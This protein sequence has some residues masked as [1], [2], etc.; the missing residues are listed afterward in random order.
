MGKFTKWLG[1][2]LGFTFGGPIGAII[3][4][5][6]GSVIDGVSVQDYND[7]K[8][9][10]KKQ[11]K[12]Y[13]KQR[14]E[15]DRPRVKTTTSG[16]FEIS[17]LVLASVVIKADGKVDQVE[18]DY[19]RLH[20]INLYGKDRA[21]HAFK[22]FNGIIKKEVSTR[23]VCI[24]IREHMSHSSRLQLIHFLFGIS[25]ADGTV[26][27]SEEEAIQKIAGYLYINT[28][29]Y[30]SIK[31]MFYNESDAAYKILEINKNVTDDEVKKA[32]RKMAKKYHPD[33][34]QDIGEEHKK[35]A[36]EK[37][38]NIQKAYENIKNERNIT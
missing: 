22:L 33:R 8:E 25:K 11:Q 21:N 34:L 20:F 35:A 13:K 14:K 2:G 5:A 23:Q 29:D 30:S 32:Y 15:Q 17:L 19:V 10:Y 31:A 1:A 18:L 7:E 36:K 4:Y 9:T 28:S 16:D 27:P 38:Q 24:Q 12:K 37:F 3:G 26:T 6:L